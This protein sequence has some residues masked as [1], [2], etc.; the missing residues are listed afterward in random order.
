MNKARILYE[1]AGGEGG[2]GEAGET[3]KVVEKLVA[4]GATGDNVS[5]SRS[6]YD[7]L[8][9]QIATLTA[10]VTESDALKTQLEEAK[11]VASHVKILYAKDNQDSEAA[12]TAY[13][14]LLQ[15]TGEYT[16]DEADAEAAEAFKDSKVT[17][18][19]KP[20]D[21]NVDP[22]ADP[23]KLDPPTGEQLLIRQ[24]VDNDIAVKVDA[25]LGKGD[26]AV[27]LK[28]VAKQEE[29]N[30]SKVVDGTTTDRY[31]NLKDHLRVQTETALRTKLSQLRAQHGLAKL[32][33]NVLNWVRDN[34]A[35]A[36]EATA[37][38][39]RL[40]VGDP[41]KLGATPMTGPDGADPFDILSDTPVKVPSYVENAEPGAPSFEKGIGEYITDRLTRAAQDAGAAKL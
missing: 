19:N 37:G 26:L 29:K 17:D 30:D 2:G 4:A 35:E 9:T 40:F 8:N 14:A 3:N 5:I 22:N 38:K 12:Q 18:P 10:K 39:A 41:A 33:A 20:P 7:K 25:E 23:N 36:G 34:I 1:A 32:Q 24:I 11:S 13:A 28:A 27:L 6:D 31:K 16:K 15:G 21:K